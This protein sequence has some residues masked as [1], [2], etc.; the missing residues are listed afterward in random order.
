MLGWERPCAS[1]SNWKTGGISQVAEIQF[2]HEYFQ[3]NWKSDQ[4]DVNPAK[5]VANRLVV[6]SQGI[7]VMYNMVKDNVDKDLVAALI[8]KGCG[9][10][11][12][13]A[14]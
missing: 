6:E 4:L 7:P 9:G 1:V 14:Y 3:D 11:F 5:C 10:V 2:D 12:E 8:G 13:Q